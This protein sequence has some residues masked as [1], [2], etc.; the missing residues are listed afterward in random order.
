MAGRGS[1]D[2]DGTGAWSGAGGHRGYY[3]THESMIDDPWGEEDD[4][5]CHEAKAHEEG[6][7]LGGE[8][9]SDSDT[10]DDAVEG[11]L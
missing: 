3:A 7:G 9:G 6:V 2:D 10:Y 1:I 4:E 8:E 5:E 11:P